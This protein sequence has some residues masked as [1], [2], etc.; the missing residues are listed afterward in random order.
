MLGP[1]RI[2]RRLGFGGMGVVFEA[3]DD[4]LRRPVALK[5][6][7]PHLADDESFRARF[8]REAQAQAS[9][10]SPHVVSVYSHGEAE[11]RLYIATELVDAGDLGRLIL[12]HGAPPLAT[13]LDILSQVSSGLADAH[14]AGLVHRDI[15]PANVLLRHRDDGVQAY[16]ADFGIA[17]QVGVD[18][19]V[20]Q[21][22]GTIGT[23]AYMA[24]ELHTGGRAGI[25]SDIYSLGCLL[26]AALSGGAPYVG[27]S[28]YEVVH[29]HQEEPVPQLRSGTPAADAINQVL[30]RSLAKRP[31]ERYVGAAAM[32]R[33]LREAARLAEA[34]G[35]RA[36]LADSSRRRS[37]PGG[38]ST[39]DAPGAPGAGG[40]VPVFAARH[41]PTP[42]PAPPR[43]ISPSPA[44]V[45]YVDGGRRVAVVVGLVLLVLVV[46]VGVALAV[47]GGDD[48]STRDST[49]T[50]AATTDAPGAASATGSGPDPGTT[51]E[52]EPSTAPSASGSSQPAAPSRRQR[53][54]AVDT[55]VAA[56]DEQPGVD[57]DAAQ[58]VGRTWVRGVGLRTMAA[59]GFYD[60]RWR[61]VDQPEEA[62]TPEMRRVLTRALTTCALRPGDS[63]GGSAGDSPG[64]SGGSGG[65][66]GGSSGADGRR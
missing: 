65:G 30:L 57:R 53:E 34:T 38:P 1:Y 11:G 23:P 5:V 64:G 35:E 10:R 13:A 52:P 61:Y 16:L 42:T 45:S 33:D 21:V 41:T 44:P 50:G 36:V 40:G 55:L 54:R 24:P 7:S 43:V 47:T 58:C 37:G 60:G 8:V 27:G 17:R 2:V 39:P 25:E 14:A 31:T 6:I 56:L 49:G 63:P 12:E 51:P 46:G 9:V 4:A 20:T 15:K 48:A 22:G 3:H 28:D 62:I 66:G 59:E 32:S 19:A 29:A 26:W 18:P